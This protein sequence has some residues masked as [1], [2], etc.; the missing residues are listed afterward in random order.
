MES[1]GFAVL[2][3]V[4]VVAWVGR[5]AHAC[6]FVRQAIEKSASIGGEW[7]IARMQYRAL[8]PVHVPLSFDRDRFHRLRGNRRIDSGRGQPPLY[9]N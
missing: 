3:S 1:L 2:F 4:V 8:C 6:T 5:V 7:A 9:L